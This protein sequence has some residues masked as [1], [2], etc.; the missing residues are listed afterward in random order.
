MASVAG[1]CAWGQGGC[2]R[3]HQ[4]GKWQPSSSVT[5]AALSSLRGGVE[6]LPFQQGFEGNAVKWGIG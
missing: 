3:E 4:R 2:G 6:A 5:R 1:R